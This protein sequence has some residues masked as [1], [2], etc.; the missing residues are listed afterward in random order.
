M[1]FVSGFIAL[2][3]ATAPSSA[4]DGVTFFP[5]A[6]AY[7]LAPRIALV[8][9]VPA[10][11]DSGVFHSLPNPAND[12]AM[13]TAAL[14]KLEFTVIAPH[15]NY[16]PGLI[17]RQTIKQSLYDF[18][19]LL[20][21]IP[22]AIGLVYFSGHGIELYGHNYLVPYD[23]YIRYDRDLKEELIPVT[24]FYDAF[25]HAGNKLNF[26][27]IDACR[28][29]PKEWTRLPSFG[30]A[31]KPDPDLP[32]AGNVISA[33][34][35][36]SGKVALDGKEHLSPY[37]AAL[38][39][40]LKQPDATLSRF[41]GNINER[42]KQY[43]SNLQKPD[44]RLSG[45]DFVFF[46]TVKSYNEEYLLY[47]I[48]SL[49][50]NRSL[51]ERVT[52]RYAH[53]YFGRFAEEQIRNTPATPEAPEQFVR[54]TK[55]S[56]LRELPQLH[57]QVIVTAEPNERYGVYKSLHRKDFN[58]WIPLHSHRGDA[59]WIEQG[60]VVPLS[61]VAVPH[62]MGFETGAGGTDTLTAAARDA[63]R[64]ALK[65]KALVKRIEVRATAHLPAAAAEPPPV[66]Q[67]IARQSLV[68]QAVS[69]AGYKA[70]DVAVSRVEF[71]QDA[72]AGSTVD[73]VVTVEKSGS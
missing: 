9:G 19:A 57:S 20:K 37:A 5:G 15:E 48:A 71:S 38:L 18:A 2:W 30:T 54:I 27:F 25:L 13:I 10:V 31:F 34:A 17:T 49:G 44:L 6:G 11:K 72:A 63:L 16:D 61:L 62:R 33:Y 21:G 65:D 43:A 35:T 51:L 1:R 56:A 46:P 50:K 58:P 67:L 60:A 40:S 55:R 12:A 8:I 52:T 42:V 24:W 32:T 73:L 45:Q 28:N 29:F 68:V 22:G 4:Q 26:L 14:R 3:L 70:A 47:N 39:D 7:T 36:L 23:G 41:F 66:H 64:A 59:V 53:G 69:E